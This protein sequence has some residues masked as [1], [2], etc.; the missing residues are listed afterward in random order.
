M[1]S[2]DVQVTVTGATGFIALHCIA[3]LLMAGYRV[4]GTIRHPGR[5]DDVRRALGATP[6]IDRLE[7]C[8]ASLT[9]DAGWRDALAGSRF[10]LHTASPVPARQPRDEA[11]VITPA[12]DGTLRVLR[13]AS[14]AGVRRVVVTSSIAAVLSGHARTADR[15]FTEQDWSDLAGRMPAY[16][17]G[18]TLAEQTAWAFVEQQPAERRLELVTVNPSFVLGPSLSGA[19]NASNE[20]VRKLLAREMPGVP[21]LMFS[22]VDV[23]DVADAHLRAMTVPAAAGRRFILSEG[24]YWYVEIARLLAEAGHAV[25]TRIVPDWVVRV[26]SWF[27]PAVRLVVDRLGRQSHVSSARARAVLGWST[28]DMRETLRD[29]AHSIAARRA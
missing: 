14:E 2:A 27:D 1:N 23:R 8:E 11:E 21:R 29:T 9:A 12:R 6:G 4:R 13:A 18:K 24:E 20:I 22:L 15:V 16:S 26:L 25:P 5:A 19:D 28:R 3:Q 7:L 10:V 17:R